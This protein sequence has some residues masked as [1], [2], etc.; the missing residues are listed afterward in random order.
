MSLS[1]GVLSGVCAL[2]A[3]VWVGGEEGVV[4][5]EGVDGEERGEVRMQD[6]E[7]RMQRGESW[8]R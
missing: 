4:S 1:L 7:V 3:G 5:Q 2:P 6:G 8:V